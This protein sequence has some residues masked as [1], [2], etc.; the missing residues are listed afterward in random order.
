MFIVASFGTIRDDPHGLHLASNFQVRMFP[1]GLERL[2][3]LHHFQRLL[4]KPDGANAVGGPVRT[5]VDAVLPHFLEV[6]EHPASEEAQ[7][8]RVPQ[9][10]ENTSSQTRFNPN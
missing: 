9:H 1:R 3:V 7:K 4:V 8:G 6:E 5:T 2:T 10:Q